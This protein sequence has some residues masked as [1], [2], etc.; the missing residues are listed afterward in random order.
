MVASTRRTNHRD[1]E[2]QR[3][4]REA[5]PRTGSIDRPDPCPV[6]LLFRTLCLCVSVVRNLL[7]VLAR[8]RWG[9]SSFISCGPQRWVSVLLISRILC[10]V[11][12][13]QSGQVPS[14]RSPRWVLESSIPCPVADAS[15]SADHVSCRR[16]PPSVFF[17]VLRVFRGSF[18]IENHGTHGAHGK[19]RELRGVGLTPVMR[20]I[21]WFD[22]A[23][24]RPGAGRRPANVGGD[25]SFVWL[26]PGR[27]GLLISKFLYGVQDFVTHLVAGL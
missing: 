12:D 1:T 22:F 20:R 7:W 24:R 15:L 3:K 21:P 4:H 19:K 6:R 13:C 25:S 16:R 17:R 18:R 5:D 26:R 27:A 8:P 11:Q 23:S 10:A 14:L 9:S 2:T